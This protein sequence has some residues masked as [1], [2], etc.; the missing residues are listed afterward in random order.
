VALATNRLGDDDAL[1]R[2]AAH[3]ILVVA[4]LRLVLAVRKERNRC[5]STSRFP[6]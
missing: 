4:V 1:L 2:A 5:S 3:G 6:W